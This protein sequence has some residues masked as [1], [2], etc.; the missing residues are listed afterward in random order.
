MFTGIIEGTGKITAIRRGS[1][2]FSMDVDTAG[3]VPD[4][5]I[6]ESVALDGVCLTVT[7]IRGAILSFDVSAETVARTAF[8]NIRDGDT[9][10]I[11][12]AMRLGDRVGGHLVSGHVDCVGTMTRAGRPGQG[13]DIEIALPPDG[14][15]YVIE[16]GSIAISGI[17]LTVARKLA[18]S[19]TVAVIPHTWSVT[20]LSSKR[21]GSPVNI[22]YDMIAKYVENFVSPGAAM[23]PGDKA[24]RSAIDK[25]FL[26]SH[27][28]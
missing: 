28:F 15:K 8:K 9:V 24:G 6:G 7:A 16:K 11:E 5:V 1:S 4:P 2:D 13:Y 27:G 25:D 19:V 20:T 23:Q 18:R 14:M 17:S 21:P 26:S 10:N 12:R 22:E 3:S